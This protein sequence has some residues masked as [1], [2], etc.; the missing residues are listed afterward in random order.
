MASPF[1]RT[2]RSLE[3]DGH[4]RWA[5]GLVPAALLLAAWGTWFLSAQVPVYEVSDSARLEADRAAHPIDAPVDGRIVAVHWKL[6]QRVAA[7]EVLVELEANEQRYLLEEEQASAGALPGQVAALRQQVAAARR[8]LADG[9]STA[10]ATLAEAQARAAEAESAARFAQSDAERQEKLRTAGLLAEADLARFRSAAE[11]KRAAARALTLA[12]DRMAWEARNTE[13]DQQE[14]LA[15]LERQ[16]AL[17]TG[18]AA[19]AGPAGRRLGR[20]VELRTVRAP[21]DGRVGEVVQLRVGSVVAQGDRLGS[22]VPE[23]GLKVVAGFPPE[24]A[25]GRVRP[26][27]PAR[28]RLTGFPAN[29]YGLLAATVERVASEAEDG[30]IR[31]ELAAHPDRHSRL[32]LEHGLPGTV[33][34]EVERTTPAALVLRTVGK[35]LGR[36]AVRGGTG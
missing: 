32:P 26:G 7:A 8:M 3:S 4:R 1:S 9:R 10:K 11:Q 15:D 33:E 36:P 34:V 13:S 27:Q 16:L 29:Q 24:G 17:L 6:G 22:V 30:R 28:V 25:V 35:L 20:D 23:G 12:L 31:V 14:K 19:T 21:V 18:Q 2:L 5:L